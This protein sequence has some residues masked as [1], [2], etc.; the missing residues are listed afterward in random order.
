M[1]RSKFRDPA[2]YTRTFGGVLV[3]E[4]AQDVRVKNVTSRVFKDRVILVG[5]DRI[6]H[7][8]KFKT[9]L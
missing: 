3:G 4:E 8:I 6:P 1:L 5:K 2:A 7:E 9:T